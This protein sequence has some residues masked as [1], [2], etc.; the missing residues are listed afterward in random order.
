MKK[1]IIILAV[2]LIVLL[3]G[4]EGYLIYDHLQS[5][6]PTLSETQPPQIVPAATFQPEVIESIPAATETVPPETDETTAPT[7]ETVPAVTEPPFSPAYTDSSDPANWNMEWKIISGN[8]I[9]D[10]YT[11]ED[12][13]F[14]EDGDYFALPGVATFRGSNYRT[15][16]SYGTADITQ[17][18]ISQIWKMT[19][20]YLDTIDW[21]GCGWTGQPLVVQ[22]DAETRAIMNL[23]EDKKE[24]ENLVEA[25]YAKMDGRVHFIDMEDG[26]YTRDPLYIGMVFKGSGAIDPRGYP[27]LYVGAGLERGGAVQ[28]IYA[29]SLIDGSILYEISGYHQYAPRYWFAFDGA[30]IVD[31]ETDTL[32][33]GGESGLLYT[34]KLNTNYDKEAG[35]ISMA[36]DEPVMTA[37]TDDYHRQGRY[38][39]YEASVTAVG[40]Y[41]FLGDNGGMLQCVDVNT[42][43]LIWAQD[44]RDD[45]NATPLFDWG[46]DGRG[47]LY[48]APSMD[49]V[50]GDL[51]LCKIDAQ[52]GEILWSHEME[53]YTDPD[54]PGGTLASPLLGRNG[55]NMEDLIIFSVGRSPN[56][57]TGQVVALHKETGEVVWQTATGNYMWSSPIALYTE[58]GRGYIFQAD[59]SGTCYLMDGQTGKIL[60]T[61]SLGQTV[62]S[63]PVAFGN[64]VIL[65]SRSYIHLFEI[66]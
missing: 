1:L 18:N 43:E 36:P 52:T 3:L 8:N 4:L 25:I 12:P 58:D 15:D 54:V 47:Y 10:S 51:P 22:W 50:R 30:P 6:K 24:K 31:G 2:I 55:T 28:R 44:I 61:V 35:T 57:W 7:E 41:L 5:G 37:Y 9:V 64:R 32:I 33:W 26:S 20:G 19:V 40:N 34:I 49:Y 39:G 65:G 56:L 60:N 38:A 42:M 23:Y 48:V 53:C 17:G 46:K 21:V 66:S 63:S 14:F 29:I 59:A 11:R 13:I 27:I 45:I 62:E 16:A